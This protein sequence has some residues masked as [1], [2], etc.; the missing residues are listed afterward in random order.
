MLGWVRPS[1]YDLEGFNVGVGGLSGTQSEDST[2]CCD[3]CDL[4]LPRSPCLLGAM[5]SFHGSIASEHLVKT[6]A[7]S[8]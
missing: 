5:K 8:T 3:P 7:Q 1:V 2:T 4:T 6:C